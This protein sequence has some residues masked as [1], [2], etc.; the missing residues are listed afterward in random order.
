MSWGSKTPAAATASAATPTRPSTQLPPSPSA[1][2][3][4]AN[5][6]AS[7]RGTAGPTSNYPGSAYPSTNSANGATSRGYGAQQAST[8]P[9]YHTGPYNTGS[10]SG[11]PAPGT[12]TSAYGPPTTNSPNYGS[13]GAAASNYG[14]SNFGTPNSNYGAPTIRGCNRHRVVT[15][16][17]LARADI[18]RPR[19]PRA[20]RP[21][22]SG[23]RRTRTRIP[24][25]PETV[26]RPSRDRNRAVTHAVIRQ[27]EHRVAIRRRQLS[28][29]RLVRSPATRRP[30]RRK[31]ATVP[32]ALA[33]R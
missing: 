18:Q 10:Q 22:P 19:V 1:T 9:G 2:M 27:L 33:G 15:R 31:T 4:G 13:P 16:R 32:A 5:A 6:Y 26:R 20:T 11:T 17:R 29:T 28:A 30:P 21:R 24:T 7:N 25:R 14:A 3:G 12:G 23:T 8:A